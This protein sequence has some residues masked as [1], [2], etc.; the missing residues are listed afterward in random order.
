[1]TVSTP[2]IIDTDPGIDD[3]VALALAL[4]SPEIDILA[5][6][7]TYGNAALRTTSRN[8]AHVLALAGRDDVPLRPGAA[9]PLQRAAEAGERHGP[10]GVGGAAVPHA[11]DVRENTGVLVEVLRQLDGPAALVTLGPLTNLAHAVTLDGGLVTARIERHL[12]VLGDGTRA[13]FNAWSDPEAAATVLAADIATVTIGLSVSGRVRIP[14][15]T[16]RRS[17]ASS[18]PLAAWLGAALKFKLDASTDDCT[19]HDVVPVAALIR[20]ALLTLARLPLSVDLG[21][22]ERRGRTLHTDDGRLLHVAVDVDAEAVLALLE[23]VWG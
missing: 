11:P 21:D 9:A 10:E 1:M 4:R 14:G 6:T 2:V 18:D 13:D 20:P 19:V 7:T 23:R 16:V 3:A 17:A 5:V 15:D 12:A 8:A 22:G